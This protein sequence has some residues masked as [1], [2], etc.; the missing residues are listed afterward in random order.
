MLLADKLAKKG[1]E[2]AKAKV[3]KE[4]SERAKKGLELA[5]DKVKKE[6]S[7]EAKKGLE[8]AKDKVKKEVSDKAKKELSEGANKGLKLAKDKAKQKVSDGAKKSL[9]LLINYILNKNKEYTINTIIVYYTTADA[10][11]NN[12]IDK[13]IKIIQ[14]NILNEHNIKIDLGKLKIKISEILDKI[15][16][17]EL[18]QLVEDT[19]LGNYYDKLDEN[20]KI[21]TRKELYS[22]IEKNFE[23]IIKEF[24]DAIKLSSLQEK[25]NYYFK[26]L[27]YKAKYL[28]LVEIKNQRTIL[29]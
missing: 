29:F 18:S 20:N 12:S 3:K 23:Q 6:V 11:K 9:K 25:Y 5:K 8:L 2:L 14:Q 21:E 28:Q 22:I 15:K 13:L 4:V 7:E 1:L 24:V 27:K 26:Y 17:D 19:K 16:D 10:N